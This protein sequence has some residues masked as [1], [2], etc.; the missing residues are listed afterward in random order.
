MDGVQVGFGLDMDVAALCRAFPG[1]QSLEIFAG[2][3]RTGDGVADIQAMAKLTAASEAAGLQSVA[4]LSTAAAV[5]ALRRPLGLSAVC[6]WL[7]GKQL[8][9]SM[10]VRTTLTSELD[11]LGIHRNVWNKFSSGV[12]SAAIEYIYIYIYIYIYSN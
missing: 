9:K 3:C 11:C 8:D 5:A 2:S 10:Q 12:A 1:L 6:R 7:L 4:D